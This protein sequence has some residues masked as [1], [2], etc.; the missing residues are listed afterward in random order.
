MLSAK[1][2]WSQEEL[3]LSNIKGGRE[4]VPAASIESS[5][6]GRR[7]A[8]T[9]QEVLS[10]DENKLRLFHGGHWR[11]LEKIDNVQRKIQ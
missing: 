11:I 3:D 2:A 5:A 7:R 10:R 4:K 9:Q 1:P 6:T 8:R